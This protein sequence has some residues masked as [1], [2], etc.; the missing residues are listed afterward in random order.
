MKKLSNRWID[1]NGFHL[2]FFFFYLGNLAKIKRIKVNYNLI[3][4]FIKTSLLMY[5]K[6]LNSFKK[7]FFSH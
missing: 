3:L 7:A 2:V 6:Q 4:Y 5:K 1:S